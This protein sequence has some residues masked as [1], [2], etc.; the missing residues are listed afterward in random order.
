LA[1]P[2]ISP[3]FRLVR[4]R[5]GDLEATRMPIG[6]GRQAAHERLVDDADTRAVALSRASNARPATIGRSSVEK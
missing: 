1:T 3:M 6:C 4:Q 2:T 5:V